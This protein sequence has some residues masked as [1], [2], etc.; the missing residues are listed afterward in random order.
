MIRKLLFRLEGL[1]PSGLHAGPALDVLFETWNICAYIIVSYF[2]TYPSPYVPADRQTYD[3]HRCNTMRMHEENRVAVSVVTET[4]TDGLIILPKQEVVQKNF[5][6][7]KYSYPTNDCIFSAFSRVLR[8]PSC[9][10]VSAVA[11]VIRTP[12]GL[13]GYNLLQA[14]HAHRPCPGLRICIGEVEQLKIV[15]SAIEPVTRQN[16]RH[17]LYLEKKHGVRRSTSRVPR[18]RIAALGGTVEMASHREGVTYAAAVKPLIINASSHPC[19]KLQSA[20]NTQ[21]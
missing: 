20:S 14:R 7:Q 6:T 10:F 8:T 15:M 21:G 5:V 18:Q 12:G 1:G 17:A 11:L 3:T 9:V 16:I 2:F 13:V 19:P 4:E